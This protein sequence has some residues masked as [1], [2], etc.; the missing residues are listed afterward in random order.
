M[1]VSRARVTVTAGLRA[2]FSKHWESLLIQL[3]TRWEPEE[4]SL[5]HKHTQTHTH[6]E[7]ITLFVTLRRSEHTQ[8]CCRWFKTWSELNRTGLETAAAAETHTQRHTGALKTHTPPSAACLS[9]EGVCVCV[10]Y[11]TPNNHCKDA[12]DRRKSFWNHKDQLTHLWQQKLTWINKS[13]KNLRL[14]K[15]FLEESPLLTKPAFI[16]SKIQEKLKV[17]GVI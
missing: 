5:E 16:W 3:K 12:K 10:Y 7:T 15:M 8:I 4:V 6:R 13:L 2:S 17:K 1:N 14:Y 11:M 9:E